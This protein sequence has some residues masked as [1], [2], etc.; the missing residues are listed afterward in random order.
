MDRMSLTLTD[1]EPADS[2]TAR[3]ERLLVCCKGCRWSGVARDLASHL[4]ACAHTCEKAESKSDGITEKA[5]AVKEAD[6]ECNVERQQ[7]ALEARTRA[8]ASRMAAFRGP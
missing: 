8:L 1:L 6:V 5:T 7:A 2:V 4:V 3:L